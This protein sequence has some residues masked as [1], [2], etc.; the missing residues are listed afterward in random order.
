MVEGL[1]F[2]LSRTGDTAAVAVSRDRPVGLDIEALGPVDPTTLRRSLAPGERS[3]LEALPEAE[4]THAFFRAWTRREAY[5]KARGTG[6]RSDPR[7][8]EVTLGPVPRLLACESGEAGN[9]RSE[10]CRSRPGSRG[11]F[12]SRWA[13]RPEQSSGSWLARVRPPAFHC[14]FCRF[15]LWNPDKSLY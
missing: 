10:S 5:L 6:L 3:A 14:E 4:R 1:F 12:A 15:S 2:S 13:G 7:G 11:R 8:C 9:G